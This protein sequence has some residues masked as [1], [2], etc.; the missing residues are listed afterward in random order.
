MKEGVSHEKTCGTASTKA[1]RW[2]WACN[3]QGLMWRAGW[4]VSKGETAWD[5]VIQKGH[6]GPD[7]K[8]PR[9]PQHEDGF[10]WNSFTDRRAWFSSRLT[11]P[12]CSW[13]QANRPTN[14]TWSWLTGL[15]WPLYQLV[16]GN[17]VSY[18]AVGGIVLQEPETGDPL[19]P[20]N[21][22]FLHSQSFYGPVPHSQ[23]LLFFILRLYQF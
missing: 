5:D 22:S 1:L 17:L 8:E 4:R 16:A 18:G 3:A 11:S 14:V 21:T 7:G 23:C 6:Q 20:H 15:S 10:L 12:I 9:G 13:P 19:R 2:A